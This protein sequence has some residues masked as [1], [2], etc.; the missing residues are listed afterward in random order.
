MTLD[1]V[2]SPKVLNKY[3]MLVDVKSGRF[4]YQSRRVGDKAKKH[5]SPTKTGE[6]AS[7]KHI[8]NLIIFLGHPGSQGERGEQGTEGSQ[9]WYLTLLL[10]ICFIGDPWVKFTTHCTQIAKYWL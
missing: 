8:I 9:G 7:M 6:L 3:L 1:S 10:W 5:K 2:V 4:K